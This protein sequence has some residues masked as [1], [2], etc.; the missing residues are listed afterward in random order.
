MSV[1]K[2][3]EVKLDNKHRIK[4]KKVNCRSFHVKQYGD[5]RLELLPKKAVSSDEISE[6][7]LKMMD[8]SMSNFKNQKVSDPIDLDVIGEE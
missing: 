5:G 1:V 8:K 3:Y 4:L 7:T 6:D 2:E